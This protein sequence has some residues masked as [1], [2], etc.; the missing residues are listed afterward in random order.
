MTVRACTKARVSSVPQDHVGRSPFFWRNSTPKICSQN[1]EGSRSSCL[2]WIEADHFFVHLLSLLD[3]G[4]TI[5]GGWTTWILVTFLHR[6]CGIGRHTKR[7][8]KKYVL[9]I[10]TRP[11]GGRVRFLLVKF[12]MRKDV[13]AVCGALPIWNKKSLTLEVDHINGNHFD[14]RLLNLQLVCPNCHS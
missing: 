12:N 14:N 4:W 5:D 8:F 13:C 7:S 6:D 3:K 9:K 10:G 2:Q 11:S 1:I